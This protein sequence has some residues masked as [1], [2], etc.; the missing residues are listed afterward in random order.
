MILLG[1]FVI[2]AISGIA[3]FSLYKGNSGEKIIPITIW[4]TVDRNTMDGY[5][6]S[7]DAVK[8]QKMIITYVYKNADTISAEF[9]EAIA[10][11]QGPDAVLLP[12]EI[13]LKD[14]N[15]IIEIPYESFPKNDFKNTYIQE[16]EIY[17]TDT[18]IMAVPFSVDPMVM[19]WNRNIFNNAVV[20][21]PPKYWDEFVTLVP[22][23]TVRDQALNIQQAAAALGEFRNINNAK[24]ILSTLIIQAGNPIALRTDNVLET[25]LDLSLNYP[26]PPAE[27]ALSF[28]TQF[29]NPT[30]QV[31]TWNRSMQSARDL[32]LKGKVAMY[33]A[34]ASEYKQLREKN[35]NLNFDVTLIPQTRPSSNNKNVQSTFGSMY[36]ISVARG[37]KDFANT[38]KVIYAIT[39][40]EDLK[41]WSDK[42]KL[43][44][45]RRDVLTVDS[46]DSSSA[47]F[48]TS[49][50]W[51]RGW[52]EPDANKTTEIFKAMVE[53]V[54]SG[55]LSHKEAVS[56]A[57][58]ELSKLYRLTK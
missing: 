36:G 18:G 37:T 32:F 52:L 20:S 53:N 21:E 3:F 26:V 47:V 51:S 56:V 38:L 4:G 5:L 1:V 34:P 11:G 39:D 6:S 12:H 14:S 40:K 57:A 25:T 42:S 45:V 23:L 13:L 9:V 31:Y 17:L 35:P 30:Q 41:I 7:S 29:A 43:P 33:F 10:L 58:N 27:S 46:A 44:S 54:T 24:Q 50:L 15:K 16:A 22:K 19:Y 48:A 49:A 8:K 2:A 55:I 28:F